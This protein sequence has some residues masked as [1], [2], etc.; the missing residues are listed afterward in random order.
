MTFLTVTQY[1]WQVEESLEMELHLQALLVLIDHTF[2]VSFVGVFVLIRL[3]FREQGHKQRFQ[4]HSVKD[5]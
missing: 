5:T 4:L 2:T 1:S 3:Y